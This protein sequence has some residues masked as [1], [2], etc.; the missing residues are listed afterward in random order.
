MAGLPARVRSAARGL[1]HDA[2][3]EARA[4]ARPRQRTSLRATRHHPMTIGSTIHSAGAK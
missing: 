1:T 4:A 3:E 2:S